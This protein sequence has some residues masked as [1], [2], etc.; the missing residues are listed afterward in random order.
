MIDE[1]H[2][3]RLGCVHEVHHLEVGTTQ[4]GRKICSDIVI[5]SDMCSETHCLI[6]LDQHQIIIEDNNVSYRIRMIFFECT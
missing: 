4:I 2:L 5:K 1:W 6:K 3:V